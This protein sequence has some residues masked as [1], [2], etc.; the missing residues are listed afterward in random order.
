MPGGFLL[1]S[2]VITMGESLTYDNYEVNLDFF[3]VT[4]RMH[5]RNNNFYL[6]G[7]RIWLQKL[8]KLLIYW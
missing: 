6:G 1:A 5:N 7:I 3:K 2:S 8:I 4:R